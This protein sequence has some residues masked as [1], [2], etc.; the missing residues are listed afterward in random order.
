MDHGRSFSKQKF[1]NWLFKNCQFLTKTALTMRA[2]EAEK[3]VSHRMPYNKS[4]FKS[5]LLTRN[6]HQS[7]GKF[8]TN[9]TSAKKYFEGKGKTD[10]RDSLLPQLN[11]TES[12]SLPFKKKIT[13]K[14]ISEKLD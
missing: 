6:K 8:A 7:L 3:L 11:Q 1:E 14:D 5:T 12:S 2:E 10:R 13:K 9:F 4:P